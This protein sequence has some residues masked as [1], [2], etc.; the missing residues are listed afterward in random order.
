MTES[1]IQD[2]PF[3]KFHPSQLKRDDEFFMKLAFNQAIL[4]WNEDEVP[5]GAV[6]V[7]NAEVVGS[8]HNRVIQLNDP[9][10]HAEILAITQASKAVG[11]WRLNEV[12]LY[13]TKEPCPMCSG[14]IIMS[15]VRRVIYAI[16]DPKMGC[17][18]GATDLSAL[19]QVNHRPIIVKGVLVEPCTEILRAF[20]QRKRKEK[21]DSSS[22]EAGT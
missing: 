21:G 18:G 4:A 11:D 9:T 2:C 17:M 13:V 1:Q 19:P 22:C 15:R 8:D 5:V 14:A 3:D 16:E 10:A 20:F 7:L 6:A 12:D